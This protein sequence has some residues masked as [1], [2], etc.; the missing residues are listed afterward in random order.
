MERR[1]TE[2]GREVRRY[3]ASTS[4]LLALAGAWLRQLSIKSVHHVTVFL[5]YSVGWFPFSFQFLISH[6]LMY[7]QNLASVEPGALR[8]P[9]LLQHHSMAH[10]QE[11]SWELS[12]IQ[13]QCEARG[14]DDVIFIFLHHCSE[15]DVIVLSCL[16]PH[17]TATSLRLDS[18]LLRSY[19][20][21]LGSQ[22]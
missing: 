14:H 9:G 12:N 15:G 3:M 13:S 2:K 16:K 7:L 11:V 10:C 17:Y 21:P 4:S 8:D 18:L 19:L 5:C 20:L 22:W 6:S 1:N